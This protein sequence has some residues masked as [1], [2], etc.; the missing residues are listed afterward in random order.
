MVNVKAIYNSHYKSRL[1]VPLTLVLVFHAQSPAV[2]SCKSHHAQH[3][4]S[5]RQRQGTRRQKRVFIVETWERGVEWITVACVRREMSWQVWCIPGDPSVLSAY[6]VGSFPAQAKTWRSIPS[7]GFRVRHWFGSLLSQKNIL[8][9]GQR[10]AQDKLSC[11]PNFVT[12]YR[13]QH[14]PNASLLN[15]IQVYWK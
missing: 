11:S 14:K 10:Y 9:V 3:W 15:G 2:K 8:T 12:T 13:S 4:S 5:W 6:Q 7:P 1:S